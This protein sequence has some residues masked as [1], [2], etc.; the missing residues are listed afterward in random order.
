M[1]KPDS[2]ENLPDLG[3]RTTGLGVALEAVK[4]SLPFIRT[5]SLSSA[6]DL[7]DRRDRGTAVL[8]PCGSAA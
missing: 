8:G 2:A 5:T 6:R 1:A 4:V 7:A 3:M